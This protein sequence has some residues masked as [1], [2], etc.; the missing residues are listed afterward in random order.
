MGSRCAYGLGAIL[1]SLAL[2]PTLALAQEPRAGVVSTLH[3]Q[4]TLT[5][6]VLPGPVPLKFKDDVFRRD[7]IDTREKSIARVLLG[8]KALVTVRELST[9]TI[10]EEPGRAVVNL[11]SGKLALAVAK[12]RLGPGESIE[13]RTP[14]A[15]A[16]VRGSLLVVEVKVID[17]ILRSFFTALQVSLPITVFSRLD[18]TV[19]IPLSANQAM[20]VS[21]TAA[22]TTMT[23]V[24][25]ISPQKAREEAKTAAAGKPAEHTDKSPGGVTQ[26]IVERAFLDATQLGQFPP[27]FPPPPPPPPPPPVRI[28]PCVVD[29]KLCAPP[30]PR[31]TSDR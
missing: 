2:W 19:I 11:E 29:P 20:G 12:S 13:V 14:N 25:T 23:P 7:R 4:A 28:D 24:Q 18:P 15:I 16:G 5:R 6:A 9:F 8:G 17:G 26:Q 10:T 27:Q 3:G 31:K 1:L 21:G 22:A 30:P